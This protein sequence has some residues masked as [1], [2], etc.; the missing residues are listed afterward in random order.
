MG[1]QSQ[2][3]KD[4]QDAKQMGIDA[5]ALNVQQP[6]ADWALNAISWLFTA[7]NDN[8]FKLFFSFD[9]SSF[10]C[11]VDQTVSLVNQYANHPNQFKYNNKV[12]IS[13]FLGGCRKWRFHWDPRAL[14]GG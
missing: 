10:A 11:S 5:F 9:Y 12:F 2:A 8:G 13:S 14:R 6:N 1:S 4:V 3:V 7:A